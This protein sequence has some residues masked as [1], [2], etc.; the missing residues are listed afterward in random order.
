MDELKAWCCEN[1]HVL[2]QIQFNANGMSQL[3]LYRHA[4][5]MQ[6]DAPEEVDVLG[7][8]KGTVMN[9]RCDVGGCGRVR[10]WGE[11]NRKAA[12]KPVPMYNAE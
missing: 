10:T 5:D 9:I 1:G 4:L 11:D 8:V 6:A 12:R 2:G 3:L 7:Y